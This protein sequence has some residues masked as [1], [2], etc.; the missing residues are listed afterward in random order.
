MISHRKSLHLSASPGKFEVKCLADSQVQIAAQ[1][2][3]YVFCFYFGG[4]RP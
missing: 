2:N 4:D 1:V 3:C